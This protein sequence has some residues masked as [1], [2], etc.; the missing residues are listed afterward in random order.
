[1]SDLPPEHTHKT[2]AYLD[3]QWGRDLRHVAHPLKE[4]GRPE[5]PEDRV[6][7][8]HRQARALLPALLAP[9]ALALGAAAAE[10]PPGRAPARAD[11]AGGEAGVVRVCDRAPA[12]VGREDAVRDEPR[13]ARVLELVQIRG[14]ERAR[15]SEREDMRDP[16]E[17][18]E[19]EEARA[20][21]RDRAGACLALGRR[22]GGLRDE[23]HT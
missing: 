13:G 14:D 4:A 12:V 10:R 2:E 20:R 23:R 22:R 21:L 6:V 18:E 1:M 15:V 19:R 5:P 17:G 11:G 3:Q 16:V 9:L 7:H 8:G